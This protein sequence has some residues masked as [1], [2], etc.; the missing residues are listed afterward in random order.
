MKCEFELINDRQWIELDLPDLKH[1]SVPIRIAKMA[2]AARLTDGEKDPLE[3]LSD[4]EKNND[5][6]NDDDR[7]Q[8]NDDDKELKSHSDEFHLSKQMK[9]K[10][11]S[12]RL[13]LIEIFAKNPQPFQSHLL[14]TN[15]STLAFSS[16]HLLIHDQ[17]KLI[18]FD[19]KK[20]LYEFNWNDNDF[21]NHF[22]FFF[23]H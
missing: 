7:Q 8:L 16:T 4:E 3:C 19:L 18:L 22:S 10:K 2:A 21:G 20:K 9:K 13:D 6:I 5:T 17:K 14:D 1:F 12:Q 15:S 11:L 23:N